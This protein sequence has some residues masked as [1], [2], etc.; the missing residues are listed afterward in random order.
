MSLQEQNTTRKEW[1][2]KK[3]LELDA[4]NKNSQEYKVEAI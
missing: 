2:D 1:M 3:I 4:S